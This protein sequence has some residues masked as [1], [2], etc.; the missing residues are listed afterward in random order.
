MTNGTTR[1]LYALTLG[2]FGALSV[3]ACGAAD[4]AP[5]AEEAS[6]SASTADIP[7]CLNGP[8][9][10]P[11][12]EG[13]LFACKVELPTDDEQRAK[14]AKQSF[15]AVKDVVLG[16][17]F[18]LPSS[19]EGV[20]RILQERRIELPMQEVTA[21]IDL[22]RGGKTTIGV[23]LAPFVE[24]EGT[25]FCDIHATKGSVGIVAFEAPFLP[26]WVREGVVK[27]L[28]NSESTGKQLTFAVNG[29]LNGA[30]KATGAC[31]E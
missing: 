23:K 26:S 22:G 25:G 14:I 5:P 29:A 31:G 16:G 2:V 3:T 18:R 30:R 17:T 10:L 11:V 13:D 12:I 7:K 6:A 20:G 21:T 19:L 27:A 24:L 9:G 28:N 1:T 4:G 8:L 15:G